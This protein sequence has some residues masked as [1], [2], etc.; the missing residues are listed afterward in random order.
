M[1]NSNRAN[2]ARVNCPCVVRVLHACCGKR[3]GKSTQLVPV[4]C[5]TKLAPPPSVALPI[6]EH[7]L[8]LPS[9]SRAFSGFSFTDNEYGQQ[10]N[11]GSIEP[12]VFHLGMHR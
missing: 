11:T 1:A 4:L 12:R 6:R 3:R 9:D 10:Q 8:A 2:D 5:L 7:Y